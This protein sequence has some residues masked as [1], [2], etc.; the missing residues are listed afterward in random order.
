VC[1]PPSRTL[2]ADL[3]VS[4]WTVTQAYAQLVTEGYLTAR[5]GS[6]TRVSWTPRPGLDAAGDFQRGRRKLSLSGRRGSICPPPAPTS[7]SFPAANGSTRSGPPPR[8]R[9]SISWTTPSRAGIRAC[10]AVRTDREIP[11]SPPAL[12]QLTPALLWSR[13]PTTGIFAR[14]AAGS[15]PAVAHW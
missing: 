8:P 10:E 6:A 15:G 12:N 9:R 11:V 7:G 14:P 13:G 1:L 2:A 4:R 3:G 5:T